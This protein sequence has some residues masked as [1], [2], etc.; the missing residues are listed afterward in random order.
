MTHISKLQT[1]RE[2]AAKLI[3]ERLTADPCINLVAPCMD[4]DA[5]DGYME[6]ND[7]PTFLEYNP[8]V[9]H[10]GEVATI[11]KLE[12]DPSLTTAFVSGI[13]E[14]NGRT[15]RQD[16]YH[17][18]DAELCAIADHLQQVS[19]YASSADSVTN[20][21][22]CSSHIEAIQAG[23]RWGSI[24]VDYV[25]LKNGKVLG[26]TASELMLYKSM[27]DATRLEGGGEI[28]GIELE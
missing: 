3:L 26:I 21:P 8:N 22:V 25:I 13:S 11:F 4:V 20:F 9:G 27:E 1:V 18:N 7:L 10:T 5:L 24:D 23:P 15:I 16:L 28:R 19:H 6:K 17:L 14:R 2:L 12:Y